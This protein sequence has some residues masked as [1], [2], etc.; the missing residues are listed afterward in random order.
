[1]KKFFL[2]VILL[3]IGS[4]AFYK[5]YT[6]ERTYGMCKEFDEKISI[7]IQKTNFAYEDS[8]PINFQEVKI[9]FMKSIRI[10]LQIFSSQKNNLNREA[11]K[12]VLKSKIKNQILNCKAFCMFDDI[13]AIEIEYKNLNPLELED[14]QKK[15]GNEFNNYE[16][17]WTEIS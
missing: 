5:F 1:M 14:L 2:I 9:G 8:K 6:Y 13:Y 12:V 3:F 7:A 4:F 11:H 16:I 10:K 17:I 15:F